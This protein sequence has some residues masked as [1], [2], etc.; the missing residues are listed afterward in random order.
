MKSNSRYIKG[1][2]KDVLRGLILA[3][4]MVKDLGLY[5]SY[6]FDIGNDTEI[7]VIDKVSPA[8]SIGGCFW[9]QKNKTIIIQKEGN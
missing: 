6:S 5:T 4:S 8:Q 2:V 3:K 9:G 1:K 7:V